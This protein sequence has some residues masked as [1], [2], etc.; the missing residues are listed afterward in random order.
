VPHPRLAERRFVL[1]P[2]VMVAPDWRHPVARWSS[3]RPTI[4]WEA[5]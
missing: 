3:L 1:D 5:N 2:L 4:P